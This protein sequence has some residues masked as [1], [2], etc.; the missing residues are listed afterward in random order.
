MSNSGIHNLVISPRAQQILKRLVELYLQGGQ[1][2]GSKTLAMASDPNLSP[3]TIR[4]VV[5]DLEDKGFLTSPH[6]SAGRM[7]T[8][9]GLRFFVD[10]L[11]KVHPLSGSEI[12]DAQAQLTQGLPADLLLNTASQLL[13]EVTHLVGIVTIPKREQLILRHVEF[14]NLSDNRI[15]VVLV[16][17]EQD[18]QNRI[19]VTEQVYSPSELKQASNFLNQHFCGKALP[20]ARQDLVQ[21]LE[22]DRLQV[23]RFMRTVID[24]ADKAFERTPPKNGYVLSGE[25]NLVR[26]LSVERDKLQQLFTVFDEKRQIL[27]LLDACLNTEGVQIF[28]GEESGYDALQACSVVTSRYTLNGETLGVLGVIGPT[29]MPYEKIIPVVELTAKLLGEALKS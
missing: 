24:V 3:A 12:K 8:A 26:S 25:A 20:E 7:P 27:H 9:L 21:A 5:G 16:L 28:I 14:L 4:K 11:L 22:R 6:T 10:S 17:N 29:R 19:I 15:L 23:D 1:P 18:V 13:S 2:V